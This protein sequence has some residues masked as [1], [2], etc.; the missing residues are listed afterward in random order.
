MALMLGVLLVSGRV[1]WLF[2][3]LWGGGVASSPLFCV[4]LDTQKRRC[5]RRCLSTRNRAITVAIIAAPAMETGMAMAV[6]VFE[7]GPLEVLPLAEPDAVAGPNVLVVLGVEV[8]SNEYI[9]G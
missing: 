5:R 6:L 3:G 2:C 8:V 9:G 7:L 1:V 4:V